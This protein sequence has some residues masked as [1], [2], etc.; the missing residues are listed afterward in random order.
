[1]P[2]RSF[3]WP[4]VSGRRPSLLIGLWAMWINTITQGRVAETPAW[5]QRLLDESS[6]NG[7]DI[8]LQILGH[9]AAMSSHFYLGELQRSARAGRP[10]PRALRPIA[11]R[12]LDA[13]G[14]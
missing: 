5:A 1:M 11:C 10:C 12:A 2:R 13:D 7:S 14:K 8:D 9:R 3:G 6:K 4:R